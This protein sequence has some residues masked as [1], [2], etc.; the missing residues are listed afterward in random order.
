[1]P[2]CASYSIGVEPLHY[3]AVG[4]VGIAPAVGFGHL[5]HRTGGVGGAA[6]RVPPCLVRLRHACDCL[7]ADVAESVITQGHRG[8]VPLQYADVD[9]PVQQVIAEGLVQ[10][11]TRAQ[12]LSTQQ[13]SRCIEVEVPVL[14]V[15]VQS[16][17]HPIHPAHR[18]VTP[19]RRQP[20]RVARQHL[21]QHRTP[22][23]GLQQLVIKRHADPAAVGLPGQRRR[24][25][26]PHRKTP[27]AVGRLAAFRDMAAIGPYSACTS[28]PR[29]SRP[30]RKS[31][32]C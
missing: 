10:R 18:I 29:P 23:V 26:G 30:L 11:M 3:I 32:G 12:V 31:I 5:M 9:Q 24:S 6:T 7:A 28:N 17:L 15:V 27:H 22:C 21:P 14:Q 13:V 2:R 8:R 16:G 25:T 1:M 4:V 20:L 19:R